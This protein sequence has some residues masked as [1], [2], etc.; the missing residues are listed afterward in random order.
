MHA[1]NGR[2]LQKKRRKFD[3]SFGPTAYSQNEVL[4]FVVSTPWFFDMP[5][6]EKEAKRMVEKHQA[7]L[8]FHIIDEALQLLNNSAGNRKIEEKKIDL[9]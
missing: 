1:L 6:F 4:R 9:V 2:A 8:H 3:N 5:T 7:R